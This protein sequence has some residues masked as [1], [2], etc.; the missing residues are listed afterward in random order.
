MYVKPSTG[1]VEGA[2]VR[3]GGDVGSGVST[4]GVGSGVGT[5][6]DDVGSGVSTGIKS[7]SKRSCF[8]HVSPTDCVA[9]GVPRWLRRETVA[10][11]RRQRQPAES[12][13]LEQYLFLIFTDL[14]RNA[15]SRATLHHT[16][17]AAD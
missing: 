4:D 12:E 8:P 1:P 5:N 7:S 15:S 10:L 9:T 6:G 17:L 2:D 3:V 16:E 14:M 13:G 11:V